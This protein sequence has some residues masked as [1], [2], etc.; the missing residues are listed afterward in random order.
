[1]S[2]F[3]ITVFFLIAISA[4]SLL[5]ISDIPLLYGMLLGVLLMLLSYIDIQTFK[6]PDWLN[7]MILFTGIV[8]NLSIDQL[9]L[10]FISFLISFALFYLVSIIY[11]KIKGRQGLGGGDIKLFACGAVWLMPYYIPLVLLIS[12]ISALIYA[13]FSSSCN[14]KKQDIIP[15]GPFLALGIW[16]SLLFGESILNFFVIQF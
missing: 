7:G 9:W 11:I 15:Y 6:I 10:P 4:F 12:S 14:S 8:Y 16:M 5:L 2:A 1:M 13:L 3:K